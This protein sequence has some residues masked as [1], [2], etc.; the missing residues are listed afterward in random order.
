MNIIPVAVVSLL[1]GCSRLGKKKHIISTFSYPI[2]KVAVIER[3]EKSAQE[4]QVSL[5]RQIFDILEGWA[6]TNTFPESEEPKATIEQPKIGAPQ[7]ELR[8]YLS[9]LSLGE[10]ANMQAWGLTVNR[11][12]TELWKEKKHDLI[13]KK[14]S[15]LEEIAAA[16]GTESNG[17]N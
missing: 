4:N 9:Q 7:D 13:P 12:A 17:A 10:L 5:S 2:S 3:I 8:I 11:I 6:N 15:F 16:V 1:G 14:K